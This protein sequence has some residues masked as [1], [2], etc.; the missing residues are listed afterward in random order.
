MDIQILMTCPHLHKED[1]LVKI[2]KV[3]LQLARM[4]WV[5]VSQKNLVDQLVPIQTL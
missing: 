2:A 4:H 5:L 1:S 3:K